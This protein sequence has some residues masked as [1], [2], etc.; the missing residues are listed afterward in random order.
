MPTLGSM[1]T[2]AQGNSGFTPDSVLWL[3]VIGAIL[4]VML[5]VV[6][7]VVKQYRRCPSNRILIVLDRGK[8]AKPSKCLHG[9]GTFVVPF[10]QSA[11]YLNLDPIAIDINLEGAITRNTTRVNIPSNFTVGIGTSRVLMNNA[12][13]HL[14]NLPVEAIRDQA[15]RI[16]IGQLRPVI[17][18]F[19]S[20]EMKLDSERFINL[21]S[22]NIGKEL[23]KIG[24]ELINVNVRHIA[25]GNV[26]TNST[27]T[28]G[29]V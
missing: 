25:V 27:I 20:E 8:G 11:F 4:L 9:G 17:A 13:E 22:E 5:F 24:L 23:N 12:A 29:Q 2:L 18:S 1:T 14:L 15:Q 21:M 28:V 3:L 26:N 7:I 10:I 16:I 19:T 6:V